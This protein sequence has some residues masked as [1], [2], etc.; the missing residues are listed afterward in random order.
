MLVIPVVYWSGAGST[1]QMAEAV[2]AGINEAGAFAKLLRVNETSAVEIATFKKIALG[3]PAM[4]NE[5]LEPLEFEGFMQALEAKLDSKKLV[6]FGS[7][8]WGGSYMQA[9]Q[10]RVEKAGARLM[11]EPVLALN[12]PDEAALAACKELGK[13]LVG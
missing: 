3:C 5:E 12:E 6:L 2:A 7:Y 9:W 1:K 11:A 10:E 8:G 4:G 13:A